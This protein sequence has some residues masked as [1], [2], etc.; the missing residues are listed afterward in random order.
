LQ[1]QTDLLRSL[2]RVDALTGLANRRHFDEKLHDEWRRCGR[3]GTPLALILIDLDYFKQFNDFYGH[4]AGDGCL[5]QV[6]QCLGAGFARASDLV[7]R[8]GGEEFVCILPETALSGAEEK[9]IALESAVRDLRIP[10]EKSD[11]AG[12][13][14][15]ISLGVAVTVPTADGESGNLVLSADRSLYQAKKAG[16]GR[17]VALQI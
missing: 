4:Q 14:V 9:A 10:H 5:Q 11:V 8:Y 7:A 16:R 12:H 1:H 13:T 17:V 6:A 3:S 2:A 15:T